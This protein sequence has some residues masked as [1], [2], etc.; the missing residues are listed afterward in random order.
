MPGY[1]FSDVGDMIR[2][3]TSPA[4]EEETDLDKIVIRQDFF[5]AI[6]NGYMENMG[7]QLT[8]SEQSGFIYAGK[9]MI[10]MQALRFYTDH[11]ND[12]RYYGAIYPG[13]NLNR[14]RNQVKLLNEL[15]RS[16]NDL[17]RFF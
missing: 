1:F 11:L 5:A 8:K 15:F 7:E 2:T 4:N 10:Y 17:L 13:H 16:E 12:D 3:Y 9:F 6:Y 14:A